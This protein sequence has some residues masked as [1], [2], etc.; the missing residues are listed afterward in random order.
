MKSLPFL[1]GVNLGGWLVLEKWMTPRLFEGTDAV[2]EHTF[3]K[4][5]RAA[6]KLRRHHRSFITDADF[7]WIKETGL[8]A[9]RI[10]V[11][12]WI[13]DGDGLY[14]KAID[15]LDWAV[16]TAKKYGL[17][18]LIDL[19][20]APGSQNG[21]DHSGKVGRAEWY[22]HEADRK[23]TIDVLA[24]LAERYKKDENVIGLELLN[25][26]R[27]GV[28]NW[29]LRKFYREAYRTISQVASNNLRIV[30]HDAFTP[31]LLSG[32]LRPKQHKVMMDVHWYHFLMFYHKYEPLGWYF[33]RLLRKERLY[34]RL[35][36]KQPIIIGEWSIVIAD[37]SLQGMSEQRK[38]EVMKEH[39][40]L[41]RR[42]FSRTAGW[43]YWTY[44]TEARGA[45]HFRSLV[46]DGVISL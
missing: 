10:P 6:E 32:I 17:Y 29:K 36:K 39:V 31:R 2:D 26:P 1:R 15:R 37:S 12:Y 25:E 46:E 18:V 30:F 43:F 34:R 19:H 9:I 8:N 42:V 24:R 20:G 3:M 40:R 14:V 27:P 38:H 16:K 28:L 45:W 11:G 23:K 33:A 4:M 5:P 13:L 22:K 21:H 44:K 7:R 35:Q 41:Q